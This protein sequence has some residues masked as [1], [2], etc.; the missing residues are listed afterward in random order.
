[1]SFEPDIETV[2][3]GDSEATIYGH[4]HSAKE[5][6]SHMAEV[7]EKMQETDRFVWEFPGMN[8]GYVPGET[9]ARDAREETDFG[10]YF[11]DI[12]ELAREN[13]DEMW[14]PDRSFGMLAEAAEV[15]SYGGPLLISG[16]GLYYMSEPI[17][18]IIEEHSDREVSVPEQLEK[19]NPSQISENRRNFLKKGGAALAG[20]IYLPSIMYGTSIQEQTSEELTG[21]KHSHHYPLNGIDNRDVFNAEG[22]A[23][24]ASENSGDDIFCMWGSSHTDRIKHYLQNPDQRQ[25]KI[26]IYK[27][28]RTETEEQMAYWKDIGDTWLLAD[29]IDLVEV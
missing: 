23:H 10:K 20:A 17:K 14:G 16:Y 1:M 3:V 7:E 12:E 18:E 4:L 13:Y 5:M 21:E 15:I 22:I 2:E 27:H 9:T 26:D 8:H 25:S 19:L 24:V 28:I 29:K 6:E 11:D